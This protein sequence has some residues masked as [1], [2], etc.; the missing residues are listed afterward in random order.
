MTTKEKEDFEIEVEENPGIIKIPKPIAV[1]MP[2][3]AVKVEAS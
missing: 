1:P 3:P 2:E